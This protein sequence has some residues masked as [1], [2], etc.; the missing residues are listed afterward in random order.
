MRTRLLILGFVAACGDDGSEPIDA[1]PGAPVVVV[2]QPTVNQG[3]YMTETAS[4]VWTVDALGA[5]PICDVVA[6]D[7]GNRIPI[8]LAVE[9][10]LDTQNTTPWPLT[11]VPPSDTYVAE[12]SCTDERSL[13]GVATSRMFAVVGPPQPVSYASQ[14][15]PIWTATCIGMACHDSTQPQTGME[16]TAAVSYANL[17]GRTGVLCTAVPLVTPGAPNESYLMS[18]LQGSGPCMQGSRMPK[19]APALPST[20]L[21][22]IRDW[23]TNGA[24]NN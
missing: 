12:V 24:P 2:E 4:I 16:L 22:V 13:V 9:A 6:F 19:G 7:G 11:T 18:K 15:Q 5:R 8:A 17:V 23:I 10:Q 3:F 14:V 21:K 20:Q 1:P